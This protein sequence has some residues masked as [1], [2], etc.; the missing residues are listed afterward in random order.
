MEIRIKAVSEAGYPANP[1]YSDWSEPIVIAFPDGEVDTSDLNNL[2]QQ[3][4]F[5]VNKNL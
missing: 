1:I 2:I 3:N 5:Y 4:I